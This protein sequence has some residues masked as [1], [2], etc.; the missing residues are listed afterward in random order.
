MYAGKEMGLGT[1]KGVG[2]WCLIFSLCLSQVDTKSHVI[3][4]KNFFEID[5]KKCR[6]VVRWKQSNDR[7]AINVSWHEKFHCLCQS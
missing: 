6:L 5:S 7:I 3:N 4:C 1:E 2:E